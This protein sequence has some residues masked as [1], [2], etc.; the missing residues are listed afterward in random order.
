VTAAWSW[1][2]ESGERRFLLRYGGGNR[3]TEL[4]SRER[5]DAGGAPVFLEIRGAAGLTRIEEHFDVEGD[6]ARWRTQQDSGESGT[7]KQ[8]VYV[9]LNDGA[10]AFV[11]SALLALPQHRASLLPAGQ[12]SIEK[13]RDLRVA[14]AGRTCAVSLYAISGI[15]HTPQLI[16]FDST[17][18]F[19][20]NGGLI[21]E[22]WESALPTLRR[23]QM[24]YRTAWI[25]RLEGLTRVPRGPF[26]VRSAR[27]FDAET[28]VVR[29]RTTIVVVGNRIQTVGPDDSVT[30]PAG[31]QVYDAMGKTVLPGLWDPHSHTGDDLAAGALNLAGGITSIR[32]PAE[33]SLGVQR[34][35]GQGAAAAAFAPRLVIAGLMDGAGPGSFGGVQITSAEQARFVVQRYA[36]LGLDNIKLYNLVPADLVPVIAD[37]AHRRNLRVVGHVPRAMRADAAVRAG[38]DEIMHMQFLWANFREGTE[39]ERDIIARLDPQSGPVQ[40]FIRLLRERDVAVD[41]TLGVVELHLTAAGSYPRFVQPVVDRLPSNDLR[42]WRGSQGPRPAAPGTAFDSAQLTGQKRLIKA[43]FDGGVTLL[44]GTDVASATPFLLQRSLELHVEAGIPPADVLYMA[45]LGAARRLRRD[46]ETGSIQPGKLADFVVIDGDPLARMS[47]IRR[48]ALTV[49]DGV[50]YDPALLYEALSIRP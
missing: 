34:I 29:P 45:T 3:Q 12:A 22:G 16:W 37:E 21:L 17:G 20:S 8:F 43:L 41:G 44:I 36:A 39:S 15:D 9:P 7:G 6:R 19:F 2:T 38:M 5:F 13:V 23:A 48:V 30:I 33:D 31:A 10:P 50:L 14:V 42:R 24:E 11:A 35:Q 27:V 26:V 1:T 25:E 40:A 28:K 46:S 4:L 32:D 18:A 47:D 49:K